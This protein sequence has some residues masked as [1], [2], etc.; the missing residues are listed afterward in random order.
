MKALSRPRLLGAA[1]AIV[2]LG[3]IGFQGLFARPG[4]EMALAAGLLCPSIVAVVCALDLKRSELGGF[5]CFA[6]AVETGV[7]FALLSFSVA[8]AHGLRAG[9]CDLSSGSQIFLLG[10]AVGMVLAAVWGA[11]AVELAPRVTKRGFATVV[12]A[13]AAPLGSAGL[14]LL[15]FYKTPMVYAYDPF[16]G[17]FSG[18]MYDT[19]LHTDALWS[20]RA[21]SLATLTA[22]YVGGIHLERIDGRLV[23]R[24]LK[25]P[26][27]VALGAC[28]ALASMASVGFGDELGHWRTAAGVR[29]HLAGETS[30]GRC[31]VVY[32]RAL[33]SEHMERFAH[34]CDQHIRSLSAWLGTTQDAPITAFVFLDIHQK[35]RLI[36][37]SR[38]SVAKP[39]RREIYL[40]DLEYPHRVVRHELAHVLAGE[41]ARGPFSVA[42]SLGG[43]LPNPGLIEGIAEAAAPRD[44]ELSVDEWATA[45]RNIEVLPRLQHLFALRFFAGNA[46]TSYTAAGS[47]V[48]FVR[49]VH[50]GDAVA[51]WYGGA[52]L[53][54]LTGKSWSELETA[55]HA[56]L[57]ATTLSVAATEAARARFDRPSVLGRSCPHSVD[58]ILGEAG[59][60]NG[61]GDAQGALDSYRQALE[62]DPGNTGALLGVPACQDELGDS[63]AATAALEA[64]S[65]NDAVHIANRMTAVERLG[66]RLLRAGHTRAAREHYREAMKATTHEGRLRTLDIKV[67]YASQPIPREA[68]LALLIGSDSSGPDNIEALDRIGGWRSALPE[69]G[70]PD[71]LFARQHMARRNLD[72]A[73]ARIDRAL[74]L[75]LPVPRVGSEILRMRVVVACALGD[76]EGARSALSRY[77]AHPLAAAQRKRYYAALVERCAK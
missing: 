69:D 2:V 68:L 13:L 23:P 56:E 29:A 59:R 66:D 30:H 42:G 9:F 7:G 53:P 77:Q 22:C 44:G 76:T 8:F 43:W 4:Y 65:H 72:L 75:E 33:D 63:D 32:D 51:R 28:A 17:F 21:A 3:G 50:G 36:G 35:R 11:L 48:S 39:W 27:L 54:D 34:D 73:A 37:V 41:L 46:A 12:L 18:S 26:G 47:F 24:S 10:P 20:Y 45:M 25:R 71:Y 19:V 70:T 74:E 62:L 38:T 14:Q 40:H 52:S 57:D 64:I 5:G 31:H 67:H 61:L 6:R 60:L 15:L 55:W 49:R 1:I 16:V 58:A